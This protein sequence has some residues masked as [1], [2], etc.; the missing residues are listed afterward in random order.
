MSNKKKAIRFVDMSLA[1]ELLETDLAVISRKA[2]KGIIPVKDMEIYVNAGTE[3]EPEFLPVAGIDKETKK[4]SKR[5][6][7]VV[8]MEEIKKVKVFKFR[9]E[10]KD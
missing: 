6:V 3:K 7:R 10:T 8:D 5:T 9:L 4:A 1:S 2:K